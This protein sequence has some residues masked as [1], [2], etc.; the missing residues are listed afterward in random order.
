MHTMEIQVVLLILATFLTVRLFYKW[1]I[2]LKFKRKEFADSILAQ[3]FTSK[4]DT[5]AMKLLES[6]KRHITREDGVNTLMTHGGIKRALTV[7]D[8]THPT[9]IHIRDCMDHMLSTIITLDQAISGGYV[10]REQVS[11]PMYYY[12]DILDKTFG[13][14]IRKYAKETGAQSAIDF[15]DRELP[16]Y[17]RQQK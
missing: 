14:E 1:T 3:I 9:D 15:M 13:N 5:D 8:S 6:P 7:L 11:Y 16:A 10:K 4:Y 2:D 12:M 17:R